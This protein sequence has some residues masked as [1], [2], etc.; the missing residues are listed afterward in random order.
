VGEY[1]EHHLP[2][3]RPIRASIDGLAEVAFE[4]AEDGL[5]LPSLAVTFLRESPLHLA[6]ILSSRQLGRMTAC[7]RWYCRSDVTL[8]TRESMVGFAVITGIGQQMLDTILLGNR[9]NDVLEHVDVRAGTA[10]CYGRKDQVIATVRRDGQ[11]R[12]TVIM[13]MLVF[14]GLPGVFSPN[15]VLAGMSGFQ[16]RRVN[17]CQ[18]DSSV[19]SYV[20]NSAVKQLRG[21]IKA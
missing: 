19:L 4:H 1:Q 11:L 20:L 21:D 16:A 6:T 10:S 3:L 13:R 18:A 15:I 14:S 8:L 2:A 7:L 9:N 5:D 17:G 12:P